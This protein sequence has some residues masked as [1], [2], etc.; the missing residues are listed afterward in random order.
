MKKNSVIGY[1]SE[2]GQEAKTGSLYLTH[3]DR[4]VRVHFEGGLIQ[5]VS[6]N[7]EGRQLGDYL[8]AAKL[9][10]VRDLRK[11]LKKSSHSEQSVGTL[12]VQQGLL[13]PWELAE[14]L[15]KQ[16]FELLQLSLSNGFGVDAFEETGGPGFGTDARL[17]PWGLMVQLAR[18]FSEPHALDT[19]TLVSMS[20]D[21]ASPISFQQI[22]SSETLVN[23]IRSILR[24][25][26]E[27]RNGDLSHIPWSPAELSVLAL[28]DRPMFVGELASKTG[29]N[30]KTVGE[31][32]GTLTW[33]GVCTV[34]TQ[35]AEPV[36]LRGTRLSIESLIP[37]QQGARLSERLE[38]VHQ[39]GSFVA[40]QFNSLK[41]RLDGLETEKRIQVLAIVSAHMQDGK[42]L[43]STN[44]AFCYAKDPGRRVVVVDCDLRSP[45]LQAYLG[46][47]LEPGL[48]DYLQGERL[49]PYCYLRRLGNLYLMTAGSRVENSVELLS[50]PRMKELGDFLR[51]NFD[52][53]I[54]DC[55]P[56]QPI[57]DTG[58]LTRFADGIL[59]VI[60]RGKTPYSSVEI[61]MRFL[62]RDKLLGVV[63]NDVEAQLF[64]TYYYHQ[65]YGYGQKNTYP[66]AP[67]SKRKRR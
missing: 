52:L 31:V 2:L 30:E 17:S 67:S 54:L 65:Y 14:I 21:T 28:L 39:T 12:A 49:A 7:L 33:L 5:S 38:V 59:M 22:S 47:P 48:A 61:S 35:R 16:A 19:N 23:Q 44:L 42:S 32:L 9:I 55:P 57:S 60:R 26:A 63:F 46:I 3:D 58:R 41:V 11:L 62:E 27:F 10:A 40:E 64:N 29:L 56:L 1:I 13:N 4:S 45:S 37:Q 43:T 20:F 25:S 66:Y 34:G 50:H 53:V 51:N 36:P 24:S 6:S 8:A 18:D 15:R